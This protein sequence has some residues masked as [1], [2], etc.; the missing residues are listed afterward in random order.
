MVNFLFKIYT[1]FKLFKTSCMSAIKLGLRECITIWYLNPQSF[2][3]RMWLL[4]CAVMCLSTAI[5]DESNRFDAT[6]NPN[7]NAIIVQI[8]IYNIMIYDRNMISF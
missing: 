5:S 3:V 1:Y 7:K 6:L 2:R 8:R 4:K